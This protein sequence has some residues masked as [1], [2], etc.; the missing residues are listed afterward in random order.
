MFTGKGLAEFAISKLGTPYVYGAKGYN[1]PFTLALL[2]W[3]IENYKS[4]FTTSYIAKAKK[5]IGQICCDCS[6]LIS[7]YT[8]Y[9]LGSAQLY[10]KAYTRLPIASIKD[11]AIGTVLY[12]QGHVGVYIGM[13]NGVPMC[14]EAKGIL[15]GTIKSKVSDTK[16][17]YGLT[18][19]WISYTYEVKVAGTWKGYNPYK[20]PSAL[21]V[22]I[23]SKRNVISEDVKWMQWELVEAGYNILIDGKFGTNTKKALGE[24][25]QSCKIKKDYKCGDITR[26]YMKAA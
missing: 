22:Y 12:K 1:G 24:F 17:Q 8:L 2:N 5:L 20:E 19:S 11:F 4:I 3:L 26:S 25:Q 21:L 7:W 23:Y 9:V 6:G 13:E 14:V 18:F 10:Q 16:W 15:F